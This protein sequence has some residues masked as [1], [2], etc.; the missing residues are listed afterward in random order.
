MLRT[1]DTDAGV[2]RIL[3]VDD[4]DI[5]LRLVK[6]V[7]EPEGHKIHLTSS[8]KEALELME[9]QPFNLVI[10]DIVMPHINGVELTLQIVKRFS[11]DVIAMTGHVAQ[12]FYD[13]LI[14]AGASDFIQKPFTPEEMILRVRRVLKERHY[15]DQALANHR[16]LARSQKLESIGQL[17]TGIVHEIKSPLQFIADNLDFI[18]ES[19]QKMDAAISLGLKAADSEPKRGGHCHHNEKVTISE[20]LDYVRKELPEAFDQ[21]ELGIRRIQEIVVAIKTFSHPDDQI[22]TISNLNH[23]LQ[24]AALISKHEWKHTADIVWELDDNLPGMM[25]CSRE[26]TQAFLNIIVN[27]SHAISDQ[28]LPGTIDI[29]KITIDSSQTE[30]QIKIRISDTGTGIPKDKVSLIFDP[31]FTTKEAGRGTGQGLA[32]VHS[33][34]TERHGGQIKVET[35]KG[36]GST[37]IIS[38]PKHLHSKPNVYQNID[39]PKC[40]GK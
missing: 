27:A 6:R 22:K 26:I 28:H 15:Q 18:K 19:V 10:T 14:N 11:C 9:Q 13:Q 33:I 3:V 4:E 39:Q 35:R 1:Q 32:I 36:M 25:C 17:A 12:Y 24:E 21:T 34:I 29:E 40:Q 31:F 37:F 16:R 7:L 8:G 5:V 2:A 20:D 30:K 23:C 38:F